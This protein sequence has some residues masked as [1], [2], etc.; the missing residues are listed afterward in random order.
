MKRSTHEFAC[1]SRD[2]DFHQ[3]ESCVVKQHRM[4]MF[5]TQTNFFCIMTI[6]ICLFDE[7]DK[8]MLLCCRLSAIALKTQFQMQ[9]LLSLL[10]RVSLIAVSALQIVSMQ[11]YFI[12]RK[13]EILELENNAMLYKML[14]LEPLACFYPRLE[15]LRIYLKHKHFLL[16]KHRNREHV[17]EF[18]NKHASS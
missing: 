11:N 15:I 13:C 14:Q 7:H 10:S 4:S 3:K 1:R 2:K 12:S 16:L 5:K 8:H 18:L 6:P 17:F 9:N